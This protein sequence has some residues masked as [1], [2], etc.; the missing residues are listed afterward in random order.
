MTEIELREQF[1][2]YLRMN[3]PVLCD[4]YYK[5]NEKLKHGMPISNSML[6]DLLA[7]EIIKAIQSN[8]IYRVYNGK[9]HLLEISLE[10][11]V[12]DDNPYDA[13]F[14]YVVNCSKP[15]GEIEFSD[16]YLM[17]HESYILEIIDLFIKQEDLRAKFYA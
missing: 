16:G 14:L 3:C 15:G 13:R 10:V 4:I 11:V 9:N 8:Q 17:G 7:D 5:W 2:Q 12:D 1:T 6:H